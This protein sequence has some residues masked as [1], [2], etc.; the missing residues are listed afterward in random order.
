MENN[1]N[2][3]QAPDR[4]TRRKLLYGMLTILWV[5]PSAGAF[6]ILAKDWKRWTRQEF[7]ASVRLEDW[8]AFLLLVAQVVFTVQA[9][10]YRRC[11]ERAGPSR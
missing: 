8:V 9:I 6:W 7:F 4:C 1:N 10:R 2:D 11:C 3:A 5:F